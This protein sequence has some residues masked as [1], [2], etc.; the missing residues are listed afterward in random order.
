M[1][2][3]FYCGPPTIAATENALKTLDEDSALGPDLIPTRIPKAMRTCFGTSSAQTDHSH[4]DVRRMANDMES[5]L[6]CAALQTEISLRPGKLQRHSYDG[7]IKQS[8]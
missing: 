2:P 3:T 5:T 8:S 6:G 1:Y 4:F 7:A